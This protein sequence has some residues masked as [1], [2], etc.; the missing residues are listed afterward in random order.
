MI[1]LVFMAFFI[2][3]ILWALNTLDRIRAE[4]RQLVAAVAALHVKL[5]RLAP[6]IGETN[7]RLN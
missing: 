4:Q 3:T 1:G 2:G 7:A 6:G 5:D